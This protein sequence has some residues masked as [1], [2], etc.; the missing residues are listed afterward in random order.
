M[1]SQI[2]ELYQEFDN[3]VTFFIRLIDNL[4]QAG[5]SQFLSQLLMRINYND[6]YKLVDLE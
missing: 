6:F 1:E 5:S 4:N 2:K 3:D